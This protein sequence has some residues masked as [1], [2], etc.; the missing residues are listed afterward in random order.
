M[1][2][3]KTSTT[4]EGEIST[5]LSTSNSTTRCSYI[6]NKIDFMIDRKWNNKCDQCPCDEFKPNA[7]KKN[8][9]IC[10][11]CYHPHGPAKTLLSPSK[12]PLS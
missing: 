11:N 5:Q 7:F 8:D 1:A 12:N 2:K 9:M 4:D 10:M 6:K 3:T